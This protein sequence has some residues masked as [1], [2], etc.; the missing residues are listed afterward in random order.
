MIEYE[1]LC[2]WPNA[3]TR[4]YPKESPNEPYKHGCTYNELIAMNKVLDKPIPLVR[5]KKVVGVVGGNLFLPR[6]SSS[7]NNVYTQGIEAD[8]ILN[9]LHAYQT[10]VQTEAYNNWLNQNF[11]K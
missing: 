3:T 1:T 2:F 7:V 10:K 9:K 5:T 8:R 11:P 6:L 4:P